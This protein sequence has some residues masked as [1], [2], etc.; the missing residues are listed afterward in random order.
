[1]KT[2]LHQ[3]CKNLL[4]LYFMSGGAA[5]MTILPKAMAGDPV[6]IYGKKFQIVMPFL[7]PARPWRGT[8]SPL[9]ANGLQHG[10][11]PALCNLISRPRDRSCR[12]TD[13]FK[14]RNLTACQVKT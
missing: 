7:S 6:C 4:S 1:M 14:P 8:R 13:E 12:S 2:F 10:M 3:K 9:S 11:Q 5:H